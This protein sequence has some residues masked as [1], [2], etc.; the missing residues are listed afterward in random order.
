VAEPSD[1]LALV[2]DRQMEAAVRGILG[3]ARSLAIRAI[4]VDL[5][6]HPRK[7]PGC[8]NEGVEYMRAFAG[9]YRRAIVLF[10]REGCGRE[11]CTATELEN[12]LEQQLRA[13]DWEDRS[14]VI[15]L[16]PELEIWVWSDSLHVDG[17][18]GWSKRKPDLR[19]WLRLQGLLSAG[20]PKPD[21]PK[22]ALQAALRV[23]KKPHSAALYKDLAAKV[24]L[25]RCK[26][27]AFLKLKTVLQAW[28]PVT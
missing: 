12:E 18:L 25:D 2:A 20:Q 26:D 1:L 17:Q 8:Y 7:D 24:S 5:R 19:T 16:D 4:E 13:T 27:R 28:F 23:V 14:C 3:R 22:E 9:K 10:D 11:Q 21:R 15:V 6:V